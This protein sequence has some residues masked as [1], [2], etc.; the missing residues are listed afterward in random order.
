M[1]L[2]EAYANHVISDTKSSIKLGVGIDNCT[3]HTAFGYHYY[4]PPPPPIST[5][6][7]LQRHWI[8]FITLFSNINFTMPSQLVVPVDALPAAGTAPT[9]LFVP[10]GAASPPVACTTCATSSL[11]SGMALFICSAR[12][13]RKDRKAC[14]F[15]RMSWLPRRTSSTNSRV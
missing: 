7:L 12:M 8:L 15:P 1:L 4:A 6:C 10:S 2:L 14:S 9:P 11:S 5:T 3:V 13:S